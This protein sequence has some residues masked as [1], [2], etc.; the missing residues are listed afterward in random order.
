MTILVGAVLQ[1]PG[2]GQIRNV[3]LLWQ[4]GSGVDEEKL[5]QTP[6]PLGFVAV[7]WGQRLG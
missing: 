3:G 2:S 7:Q 6:D 4:P 1:G 5:G